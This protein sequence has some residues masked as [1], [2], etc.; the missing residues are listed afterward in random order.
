MLIVKEIRVM[1]PVGTVFTQQSGA[2]DPNMH[3]MGF[4]AY[5]PEGAVFK[6][7]DR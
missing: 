4:Y 7:D 2:G 5:A 3:Y 6:E 1:C